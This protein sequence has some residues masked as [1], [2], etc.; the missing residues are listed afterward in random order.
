MGTFLK[1]CVKI[2]AKNS[3]QKKV[4]VA[5]LSVVLHRPQPRAVRGQHSEAWRESVPKGP[6]RDAFIMQSLLGLRNNNKGG[7]FEKNIP[8]IK[9]KT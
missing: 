1:R 5:M 9:L 3:D 6:D 2:D 8:T 7:R 4:F